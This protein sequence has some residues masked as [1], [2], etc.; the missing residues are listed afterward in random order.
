MSHV[1]PLTW[2][3]LVSLR[4]LGI[5]F[6]V[7]VVYLVFLVVYRLYLSP[8]SKF[9]GPPLAA[10]TLWYEFYYDVVKGGQYTF[11]IRELHKKY[12]PI[13]RI[14]PYEIHI[15]D[16]EY[17]DEIYTGPTKPRDKWAWS[18]SM[19][20]NSSSHFSSVPYSLHRMRRA[21]L[22]PFFSKKAVTQ[23]EPTIKSLVEKLCTRLTG[24]QRTQEPV[25]LRFAFAGLTMDIITDYSFSNCYN[26]LDEPDFAPVWV[27]AVDSLSVQ[28]HVNKQFPWMLS[29]MGLLPLWLIEKLNPH[30]MRMINFQISLTQQVLQI[31]ADKD[32]ANKNQSHPTIF[33]EL[34]HTTE[35]PPEEKTLQHLVEE[36][37]SVVGAGI[38]TTSHYLNTTCYHILANPDIVEK[39]KTELNEAMPDGKLPSWQ[40]LERLPYLTAVIFEGYRISYGVAHRLQRVSPNEPLIY[41]NYVIPAGTPVSMTAMFIHENEKYFP[42][43][44]VFKPERWLNPGSRDRLEKY[45]V[46]FSKGTRGCLGRHLAEAEIYLTLAA[47]F[48]RFNMEIY[49]TTREDIDVAHDFF[50]PQPRK[51][52][53]GL[54]VLVK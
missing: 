46:N 36:G 6:G 37:Q 33:H 1:S 26:C 22:N 49:Q 34:I 51:G 29:V 21:P 23:L 39:L 30:I 24:F 3:L 53:K 54:R 45:L 40:K 18:A 19:F 9:P 15:D 28:S 2:L 32:A 42:E 27:Q 41:H 5:A 7:W 13:I 52:S 25:N 14:N 35:L 31:M 17:Y 44:K 20:G 10:L 48:R 12:G 47:I 50:N 11:K 16:P 38:V 43:P 8:L 4:A